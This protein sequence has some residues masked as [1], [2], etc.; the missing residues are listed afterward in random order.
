MTDAELLS[1][2]IEASGLS[3]RRF[4]DVVLVRNP[5]TVWRWLAGENPLPEA[6]RTKCEQLIADP[7]T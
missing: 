1:K 5:R 7:A 2:A 3:V 4:A 6:V